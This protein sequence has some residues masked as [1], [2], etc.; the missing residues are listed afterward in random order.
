MHHVRHVKGINAKLDPFVK[1]MAA[2]NRKQVP[3]CKKCKRPRARGKYDGVSLKHFGK[4]VSNV[5]I[6]TE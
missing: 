4:T 2:I 1:Q 3:L 5:R 6:D